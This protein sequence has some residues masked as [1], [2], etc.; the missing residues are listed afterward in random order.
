MACGCGKKRAFTEENPL[1]LGDPN[2]EPPL[3]VRFTVA[4]QQM[5]SGS[6]AWVEGSGAQAMID[7][8]WFV[9]LS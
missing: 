4:F 2:G 1:V 7:N 9:L 3:H 6:E 5:P 8:G